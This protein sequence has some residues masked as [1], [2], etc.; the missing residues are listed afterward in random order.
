MEIQDNPVPASR[1]SGS[2][3]CSRVWQSRLG[4]PFANIVVQ[5]EYPKF[6]RWVK[7]GLPELKEKHI[8]MPLT[9]ATS[10]I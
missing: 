1:W 8:I 6:V 4:A 7:V 2:P 9:L 5:K 3:L 10:I